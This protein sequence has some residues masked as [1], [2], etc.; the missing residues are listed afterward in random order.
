MEAYP[1]ILLRNLLSWIFS[2]KKKLTLCLQKSYLNTTRE[3]ST[4]LSSNFNE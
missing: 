3:F 4:G 2:A 1:V